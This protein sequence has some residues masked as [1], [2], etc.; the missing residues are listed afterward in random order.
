MSTAQR[1]ARG[2]WVPGHIPLNTFPPGNTPPN[3][4]PPGNQMGRAEVP[5]APLRE[6][7]ERSGRTA[8]DVARALGWYENR[9]RAPGHRVRRARG[10]APVNF[11]R[12]Y[13]PKCIRST[14]YERA[15]RLAD[16]IGV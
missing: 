6:A 7:F 1:D 14:S 8:A 15:L 2:R 3:P 12:S 13:G 5:V 10:L 16:A 4:F 9:R 11:G